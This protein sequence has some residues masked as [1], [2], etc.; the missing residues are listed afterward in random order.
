MTPLPSIRPPDPK[1]L[2]RI[3]DRLT[4]L[5]VEHCVIHRESNAI[6]VTDSR[7]VAHVPAAAL[8]V[9][10]M[11]PGV[12][13]THSAV[14][15]LA[16]SG[17]TAVWVG[18]NGVR[19]YAHGAPPSRSSRLLERQAQLV[20]NP[21]S[22]LS[23]ARQMYLMR[24]DG[25]DVGRL[26]MQQLRGREGA[27]VR[28]LYR[29]NSQRSGVEWDGREYDPDDFESGSLV[30]RC[31]SA[32]NSALYGVVHAVIVALG[33][34]P[35]LGFVHS[36]NYRSFVYDIADLYKADLSIPVAFDVASQNLETGAG[37]ESRRRM[38]DE[39][40]QSQVL[41]RAVRDIKT[42]LS[43]GSADSDDDD[44]LEADDLQLWDD[45][46]GTVAAGISYADR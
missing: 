9:L 4:F 5:Y 30:N 29:Q 23:V 34:S 42:L 11:G 7:G 16:E 18:E 25:E 22:R 26:S 41:E 32:A 19:Y 10:M 27:R 12:R 45:V 46:E 31:L 35:G 40:R 24:F 44:D 20:S 1:D 21:A 8:S 3:R 28:R 33:C 39:I 17:G 37:E 36:G 38:R 6:T 13:I 2:L 43:T 14:S 15:L